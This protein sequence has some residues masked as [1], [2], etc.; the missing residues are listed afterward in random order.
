M[1]SLN[2]AIVASI[3]PFPSDIRAPF[4]SYVQAPKYQSRAYYICSGPAANKWYSR[5]RWPIREWAG[6]TTNRFLRE[7]AGP[8]ANRPAQPQ[9]AAQYAG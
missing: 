4:Q 9:I 5:I 3:N 6:P 7:W 8:F 1:A 2:T